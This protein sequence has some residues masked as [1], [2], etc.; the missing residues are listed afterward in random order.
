M[1]YVIPNFAAMNANTQ[2]PPLSAREKFVLATKDSLGVSGGNK[3]FVHC[4]VGDDRT[5]MMIAAY[6]TAD[7]GWTPKQAM[8]EMNKYGFSLVH[9]RLICPRLS[10]YEEHFPERFATKPGF[11]ELRSTKPSHPS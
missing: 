7:E 9:R 1:F 5:G 8:E 4:R 3:I 11:E 10:E 6:R 2:L